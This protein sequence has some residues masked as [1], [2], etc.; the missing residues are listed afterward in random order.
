MG[1]SSLDFEE[2]MRENLSV[3]AYIEHNYKAGHFM[4]WKERKKAVQITKMKF[5]IANFAKLF[6]F[7]FLMI[8]ALLSTQPHSF[9]LN[10]FHCHFFTDRDECTE[11]PGI[12]AN[13]RCENTEGSFAC[14]CQEGYKLNNER[15]F[16]ISEE[17]MS[18]FAKYLHLL[19]LVVPFYS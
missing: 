16:C 19:D 1:I 14:T 6:S 15:S 5:A 12:C 2:K 17:F 11:I 7:S 10:V 8:T 13:G 4:S 18:F 3:I 9:F